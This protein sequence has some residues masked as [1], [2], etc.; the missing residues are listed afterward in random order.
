MMSTY[1][2]AKIN[3]ALIIL[4][5]GF[6]H[7]AQAKRINRKK[8]LIGIEYTFQD[9][10]MVGEP[11]RNTISTPHKEVK[12]DQL[13][14]G[15]VKYYGASAAN[16]ARFFDEKT[17]KEGKTFD[18]PGDG[19]WIVNPEPVCIEVNMPPRHIDEIEES[20][21]PL[22]K[23]AREIN[24]V[25]YVNPAAER[26]GMGHFNI[27]G[28][29]MAENPFF[30][31]PLLLRN[32]QVYLHKHP[33]LLHGFAEAYD[34]GK[35]SNIETFHEESRQRVFMKA[36]AEFDKWYDAAS[37]EVRARRGLSEYLL[38]LRRHTE[39]GLW[40]EHGFDFFGKYMLTNLQSLDPWLNS[41]G[42]IEQ[43]R[44]DFHPED[45]G[46]LVVE[47][48]NFRPPESPQMAKAFA[49]LIFAI[50]EKQSEP[51]T[52]EAFHWVS[53]DEYKR[54]NTGTRVAS[55]WL[56]VR[57]EL[58]LNNKHLDS[59][60]KE[61]ISV[62]HNRPI[63]LA[64]F[65]EIKVFNAYSAKNEKGTHFELRISADKHPDAPVVELNGGNISF[66]KVNL[67]KKSY[68][69]AAI[70]V[71]DW[72]IDPAD[73]VA[74]RFPLNFPSLRGSCKAILNTRSE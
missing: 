12:A 2:Y 56:E 74:G 33:A 26:S 51:D 73:V 10:T 29:K 58:R 3:L 20:S 32:I 41:R 37:P 54:F 62:V 28:A 43:D 23:I 59:A 47:W 61:Y 16:V 64:E 67:S 9:P 18:I 25:A 69:I 40:S 57:K 63:P 70:D 39:G 5:A 22:Y 17:K 21:A 50:M 46:K 34:I 14:A 49:E 35:K 44:H 15:I 55:D 52:K 60:L 7:S 8:V 38:T 45:T 65:P 6:S 66:E 27:G 72:N 4:L 71:R 19:K 30:V 13:I 24:L 48:R 1:A 11:G 42:D 31:Y 53:A 36:V 68:W